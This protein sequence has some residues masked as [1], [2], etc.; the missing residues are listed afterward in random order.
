MG[1]SGESAP[2]AGPGGD[3]TDVARVR[4]GEREYVLVGTAHISRESADL[5]ARVIEEERP[6]CVCIE[7]DARRY[8]ALV[9]SRRFESLDLRAV[10]RNRQLAP[11]LLNLVLVSYQRQLGGAL[12]VLPGAEL[13][14]AARAAE[15]HGIPVRLCDRDVRVTLR[16]A[17]AALSLWRKS[18]L[19]AGLLQTLLE[20]PELNEDDLRALRSQDVLSRLMRELGETFP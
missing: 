10:I 4:V 20:K 5:V 15:A 12:G 3:D 17:W 6:D 11:L 19:I 16:R 9:N 1:I 2:A 18:E 13:V 14:G 7:L 8:D